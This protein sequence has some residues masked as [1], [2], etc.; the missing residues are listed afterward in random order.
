LYSSA[1]IAVGS[2][3]KMEKGRDGGGCGRVVVVLQGLVVS[4]QIQFVV[5]QFSKHIT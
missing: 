5:A 1:M 3:E 4:P 2:D